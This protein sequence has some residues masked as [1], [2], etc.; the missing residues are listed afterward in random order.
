[1]GY[2]TAVTVGWAGYDCVYEV[3]LYINIGK[4]T[5]VGNGDSFENASDGDDSGSWY[6]VLCAPSDGEGWD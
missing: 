2:P 3:R 6:G 1:M 4:G 5:G